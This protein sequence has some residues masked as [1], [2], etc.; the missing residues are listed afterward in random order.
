MACKMKKNS[1][2]EIIKALSSV[3]QLGIYVAVSFCIWIFIAAWVRKKFGL[4]NYI[5][6]IGV[7]LGLGSGV[8]S[9][10]KFC[11][12]YLLELRGGGEEDDEK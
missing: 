1:R 10:V 4:G 12:Q 5:S 7:F 3:S 11:R 9:F 8:L 6:V 2:R